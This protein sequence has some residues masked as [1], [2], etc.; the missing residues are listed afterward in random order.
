MLEFS[1]YIICI[2]LSLWRIYHL[3]YAQSK[4]PTPSESVGHLENILGGLFFFVREKVLRGFSISRLKLL[5]LQ[6]TQKHTMLRGTGFVAGNALT[7][8]HCWLSPAISQVMALGDKSMWEPRGEPGVEAT[9]SVRRVGSLGGP[10]ELL[11]CPHWGPGR[12]RLQNAESTSWT[13]FHRIPI[14]VC[15]PAAESGRRGGW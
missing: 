10:P 12:A 11:E 5:S 6:T 8:G 15:E 3:L 14:T 9:K 1:S 2:F 13:S 7:L 4:S